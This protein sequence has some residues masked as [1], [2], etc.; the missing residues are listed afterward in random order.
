MLLAARRIEFAA[1]GVSFPV[2]GFRFDIVDL[3][4]DV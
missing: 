3:V 2:F 4:D 1:G